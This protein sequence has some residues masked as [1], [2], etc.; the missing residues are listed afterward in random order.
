VVGQ[1]QRAIPSIRASVLKALPGLES[2]GG[3]LLIACEYEMSAS[4]SH[5]FRPMVEL[6]IQIIVEDWERYDDGAVAAALDQAQV[7]AQELE[8]AEAVRGLN[9]KLLMED[10]PS[11]DRHDVRDSTIRFT[12]RRGAARLAGCAHAKSIR[13]KRH[14]HSRHAR[15]L[16]PQLPRHVDMTT[17]MTC[18]H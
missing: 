12:A 5:A 4:A 2:E 17:C 6:R 3:K 18:S 15:C 11:C 9:A 16:G 8:V 1:V 13:K 14:A 10:S 7:V